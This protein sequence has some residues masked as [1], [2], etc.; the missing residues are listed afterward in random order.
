[1]INEDE[2]KRLRINIQRNNISADLI[3]GLIIRLSDRIEELQNEIKE[4]K[5]PYEDMHKSLF[6]ENDNTLTEEI[7]KDKSKSK[8]KS[9]E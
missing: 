9:K 7:E 1:M 8:N 2:D 5:S 6:R 3:V 4:L